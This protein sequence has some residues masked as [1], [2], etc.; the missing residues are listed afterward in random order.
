MTAV[1]YYICPTRRPVQLYPTQSYVSS[2]NY[3][4]AGVPQP[5]PQGEGDYAANAEE[6]NYHP[7]TGPVSLADG[8]NPQGN[9]T[10]PPQWFKYGTAA[11][12]D[13]RG[14]I[15]YAGSCRL[16][17]IT[18]GASNTYLVGEKYL[19]PD[20]YLNSGDYGTDNSWDEG[21][22]WD[23]VRFV[24]Y[25]NFSAN[26][27]TYTYFYPMQDTRRRRGRPGLV[28]SQHVRQRPFKQL[29]YV[30]LR[31]LGPGDQLQHRHDGPFLS[32]LPQRRQDGER[33]GGNLRNAIAESEL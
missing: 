21:F 11:Y 23:N 20:G 33:Q 28:A 17:D 12:A 24:R 7:Y 2:Y 19:N 13:S 30:L 18:D 1:G 22:D 15:F 10:G 6:E 25:G 4:N 31:R 14:V 29:Q 26:D 27:S 5:A 8:D 3:L 32:G 9:W 16:H